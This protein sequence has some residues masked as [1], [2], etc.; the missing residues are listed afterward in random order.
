MQIEQNVVQP[1]RFLHLC[2]NRQ[3][4]IPLHIQ[5]HLSILAIQ[6]E[7]SSSSLPLISNKVSSNDFNLLKKQEE[8][9][10]YSNTR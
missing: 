6:E 4:H 2:A 3:A 10:R 5:N 8:R 9:F 7:T 1:L